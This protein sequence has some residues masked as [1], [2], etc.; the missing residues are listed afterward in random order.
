MTDS[1]RWGIL[2]TGHIANEFATGL[3][4]IP[5]AVIQA[6][7]SR[8]QASADAFAD[9]YAIANRHASYDALVNDPEVDAIYVA[10][11]HPMHKDNTILCLRAGKAVL[12][13]KP[14]TVNLAEAKEVVVVARET[15][16]FCMEAM[17][18]RFLPVYDQVRQWIAD[19]AIGEIRMLQADFGF[20]ADADEAGRLLDPAMAGGSLLDVGIYPISLASMLFG[21][22]PDKMVSLAHLSETGVDEQ[23]VYL[24]QYDGGAMAVLSG[25]VLTDTPWEA[26]IM[27]TK[28]WIRVERPFWNARTA[29]LQ[30]GEDAPVTVTPDTME[31]GYNYEAMAVMDCMRKGLREHPRMPLDE[32]IALMETMDALRAQWGMT[33]PMD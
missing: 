32:S 6:V 30:V 1:I 3:Q 16:Q 21:K 33:Y 8:T 15:G 22:Q 23:G 20:R 10:T 25:A 31:N 5:D 18:T 14:F 4:A 29:T 11:P 19:D 13:E 12:C 9:K 26:T 27:G 17:W 7:G 24:F 28:G 2:G